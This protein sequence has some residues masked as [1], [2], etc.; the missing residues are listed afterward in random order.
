MNLPAKL[1]AFAST[2]KL[3]G[4]SM[5][6]V[7]YIIAMIAFVILPV[8]VP[9]FLADMVAT[10]PGVALVFCANAAMLVYLSPYIGVV[11]ILA[12]TELVRRSYASVGARVRYR[13]AP[14]E[15]ADG[16]SRP[17]SR[18]G[19]APGDAAPILAP[20]EVSLE[21]SIVEQSAPVGQSTLLPVVE[22]SFKPTYA[23]VHNA[24]SAD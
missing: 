10:P 3:S 1:A 17:D 5:A 21:E 19:G 11:A 9:E 24:F 13:P 8:P 6:E 20:T 7:S 22:T 16:A 14:T 15:L 23:D 2:A 12:A 18:K 4:L